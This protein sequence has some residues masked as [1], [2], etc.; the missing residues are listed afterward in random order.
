MERPLV[1]TPA[2]DRSGLHS[3]GGPGGPCL[4]A[5]PTPGLISRLCLQRISWSRWMD[6]PVTSEDSI[7]A[8]PAPDFAA[9][10][11]TMPRLAD[12]S[13]HDIC[14]AQAADDCLQLIIKA[15]EDCAQ[16]PHSDMRQYP[17]ETRIL[18]SQ[19]E[20]LVLQDG[21]LYR[22]FHRPDGSVEFLQIVLPVK[23]RR[24]YIERLHADL[25]HFGRTK[26][27]YAVSRCPYFPSWR[28]FTVLLVRNCQV[29]NLHQRGHKTPVR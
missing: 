23:L 20:S 7:L 6:T 25:G 9:R 19:W 8:P 18:L 27:C 3:L 11:E 28:S 2:T 26:T 14:E 17:E 16:L 15:L 22:K 5:D 24:C 1:Q 29:C 4:T 21:I 12:I 10:C 13:L